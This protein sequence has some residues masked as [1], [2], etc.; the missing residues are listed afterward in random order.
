METDIIK[1]IEDSIPKLTSKQKIVAMSILQDPLSASFLSVKELSENINV[2]PATIVRFAKLITDD[3]FP[4]L[5]TELHRHVQTVSDPIKR[6][7]LNTRTSSEDDVFLSKVYD[8]QLN[9]LRKTFTQNLA[10]SISSAY[11]HLIEARHIYTLGSRGSYC[12]SYYLGLHL[13]RALNNVDIISDNDRMADF[14][15]RV[16]M[17][18]VVILVCLPRYSSRLLTVAK[19]LRS[20]GAKI[21]LITDSPDS[22]F[23][24]FSDIAFYAACNSNDF[25]NSIL[26]SVL[27]A[28]MLISFLI[29]KNQQLAL[30]NLGEFEQLFGILKQFNDHN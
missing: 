28:D 19:Q 14:L 12:I 29:S 3:G 9:N 11:Q 8:T 18:D 25:H 30:D 21:I 26:P 22:P 23:V 4:Q 13:N 20:I 10:S 5:Q 16:T 2:S 24:S 6:M 15:H 7:K 27:I 1:R 17:D